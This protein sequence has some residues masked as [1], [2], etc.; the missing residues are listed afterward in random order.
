MG[1]SVVESGV[2]DQRCDGPESRVLGQ[3]SA[4]INICEEGNEDRQL[5]FRLESKLQSQKTFYSKGDGC[6]QSSK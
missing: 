1:Q 5:I 4:E 2:T 3:M 6:L